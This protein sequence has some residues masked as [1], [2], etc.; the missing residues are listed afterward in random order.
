MDDLRDT[1]LSYG[2]IAVRA[3]DFNSLNEFLDQECGARLHVPWPERCYIQLRSRSALGPFVG[4]MGTVCSQGAY[5]CCQEYMHPIGFLEGPGFMRYQIIVLVGKRGGVYCYDDLHDCVY[6]LAATMK[7]FLRVGFRNCDVFY[8]MRDYQRPMVEYDDYWNSIMLY[9]SDVESMSAEIARRGY[10]SY[11]IDDPFDECPDTHFAFWTHD[12]EVMKFKENSFSVVTGGGVIQTMELMIHTVP[13]IS[14][15][16]Q[17][18]GA[19]GHEVIER[20]EFIVRQY[21]LI[22]N[23]GTVYGYDP[24]ADAVY[25]LAEDVVMFT[26][27]MGKKGYRNHRFST[28][29]EAL[30]RL[31]KTPVCQH[32]KK[33]PDPMAMFEDDD[34]ADQPPQPRRIPSHEEAEGRICDAILESMLASAKMV[35][36]DSHI[37]THMWPQEL[38][39]LADNS[40]VMHLCATATEGDVEAVRQKILGK[41]GTLNHFELSFRFQDDEPETYMG[42]LWDMPPCERC[43]RRRRY[44]V[45]DAGRRD[46]IPPGANVMAPL[47]PPHV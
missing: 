10:R 20:R 19:L 35:L 6:E 22:D 29:R 28:R 9:R 39:A 45:C 25:R 7:E 2:C 15:Y 30:V 21:V 8:T 1:L 12:G 36:S 41:V 4:K 13:R 44:K 47:T 3:E 11:V 23:F 37:A 32:P 43:V 31:E 16:H 42:F 38:K 17:L 5:V 46:L 18:L 24:A 33:T 34:E 40:S 27:V 14:C 26:C